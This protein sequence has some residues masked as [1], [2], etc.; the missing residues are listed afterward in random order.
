ME[1]K[2]ARGD[3]KRTIE[4]KLEDKD[5]KFEMKKAS[6]SRE[7]VF[8]GSGVR[9]RQ[10]MR[11]HKCDT[12]PHNEDKLGLPDIGPT[13]LTNFP[14][15]PPLRFSAGCIRQMTLVRFLD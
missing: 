3:E 10:K 5:R 13:L 9:M 14:S 15:D 4:W 7:E 8:A 2:L 1:L 6:W 12:K 11:E